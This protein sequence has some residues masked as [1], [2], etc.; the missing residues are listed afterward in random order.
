MRLELGIL[1]CFED[2]N[3]S[4]VFNIYNSMRCENFWGLGVTYIRELK[5][6]V[7]K[8]CNNKVNWTSQYGI[9]KVF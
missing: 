6:I 3:T 9:R 1:Y 2:I 7:L 4:N 5:A 8:I